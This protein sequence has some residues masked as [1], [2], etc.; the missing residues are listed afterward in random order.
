MPITE[1]G[2][3]AR[4]PDAS[5][6]ALTHDGLRLYYEVFG[7]GSTTIVFLP[8][9][10]ISHSRL[11]KAQVSYLAR[12]FRVVVYDGRGNGLSDHPDPSGKWLE[13]WYAEDCLTVMDATDTE[14]AVLVGICSDGVL[15]SIELAAS[16]PD[17]VLGIVAIGPGV[18]LLAPPL[19][20]RVPA[21]QA[22]DDVLESNE[23]WFKYNR[24][25]I[26]ENFRGFLE[27]FFGE[28]FPEPHSMK[29]IEDAVAYGLD[30]R[31]ET[32]LMDNEP[33][34][35]TKEEVEAICRQVRCPVLIIQGDRDNCQPFERGLALAELTGARH[36]PFE[37]AGHIPQAREPVRVNEL[38]YEFAG[39]APAPSVPAH[40]PTQPRVLLVSSPIGLG[41]SWRDVAIARELR[42]LVPGLQVEWLAQPPVTR[43]LE[44]CGESIHPA[45][46]DLSAE[47]RHVDAMMGEHELHAFHMLRRM[48]EISIANFM[49]FHDVVKQE[50]FDLWIADEGWEVDHFLYENPGL[51]TTPYVWMTDFVGLM[52]MTS[53]GEREQFLTT[54]YNAEM[55]EHVEQH[56]AVRN[57]SVFIGNEDDIIPGR[58]GPGMPSIRDWTREHY[59]FSGY[60]LPFDPRDLQD[61]ASLRRELGHDPDRPLIV[62]TVGG[63]AV[64][65]HLLRRIAQAFELVHAEQPEAELLLVCGPRIDPGQFAPQPGMRV[66]GYVHDLFKTLACCDLAVVQAGLSTTM[67]LIANQ[68]PFIHIPL[69]NHFEQ[70]FHVANR[71]RRYGAPPPTSYEE[72]TPRRL[73]QQM[74]QRLASNVAY[75]PVETDGAAKVAQLIAPLLHAEASQVRSLTGS[76]LGS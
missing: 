74:L 1:T 14:A 44:A 10:P 69:R 26:R 3:R 31:V 68:R 37:G 56:P 17:R 20:G 29:Q 41:H 65:I 22:F 54:D 55:I 13:R 76:A 19:P 23:G 11:W 45:S 47:A 61:R 46:R 15:P 75:A 16:H 49:V 9:T 73:A 42:R 67:E 62:A 39:G 18:R 28:M 4:Q 43:L 12:H 32:L 51:K 33:S 70:N 30:G 64:G 50:H 2:T 8:A 6:Y 52:P 34:V 7:S 27:F 21:I 59:E 58:F 72:A 63:S 48:D 53:G 57:L 71:I 5:G 25:Y 35:A 24:H 38:I 40:T 66:A 36:V 60:V